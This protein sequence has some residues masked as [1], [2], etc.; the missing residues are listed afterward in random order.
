MKPT[1][2]VYAKFESRG[3][4]DKTEIVGPLSVKE[5]IVRQFA[6]TQQKGLSMGS[7][8]VITFARSREELET[9]DT[10]NLDIEAALDA[11]LNPQSEME[12]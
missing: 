8:L 1:T 4:P 6:W 9:R 2:Q 5:M 3:Y 12:V 11:V 10:A 7:K